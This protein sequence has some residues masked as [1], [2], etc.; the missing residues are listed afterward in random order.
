MKSISTV[1]ILSELD[2]E[3]LLYRRTFLSQNF[4]APDHH[5]APF[6]Y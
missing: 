1:T 4:V 6:N 3:D 5:L 2:A